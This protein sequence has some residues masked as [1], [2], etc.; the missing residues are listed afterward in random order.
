MDFSLR[1]ISHFMAVMET[2]SLLKASSRVNVSQPALSKSIK[3][4]EDRLGVSL[5]ERLPRGVRPT[6]H[7]LAFE[8]YARRILEDARQ[9]AAE[10][11][12]VTA[13]ASGRIVAGIGTPY[14]DLVKD[15]FADFQRRYQQAQLEIVSGFSGH[16]SK[17]LAG[18]KVDFVLAMYNGIQQQDQRGEFAID[19]WMTDQFIGICP[20]GH[21]VENRTVFPHELVE[22][23]WAMPLID[24][25]AL[26][27]LQGE[28]ASAGVRFPAVSLTTDSFD[29]LH[30]AVA[31]HSMLSVVPRFTASNPKDAGLGHFHIHGL[32]FQRNIGVV[33]RKDFDLSPVHSYFLDLLRGRFSSATLISPVFG[34][35]C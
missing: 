21:P 23:Q 8:S 17:L 31:R 14:L 11:D 32:D 34:D 10:M 15:A 3:T 29:L 9:A 24:R 20:A 26:S 33:Q 7:A 19:H 2:A 18:R 16:L 6:L 12:S 13:G 28:F 25:S 5:F 1:Q 27:V 22:F 30:F 35:T 4:L